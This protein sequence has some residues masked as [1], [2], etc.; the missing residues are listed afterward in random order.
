MRKIYI[1]FIIA[2]LG[3]G[4]M[5]TIEP[6]S[7]KSGEADNTKTSTSVDVYNYPFGNE[8][9][10]YKAVINLKLNQAQEANNITV[11]I[12]FLKYNKTLLV[13]LTQDDCK[14]AAFSTTWAA[15][16]G[17][18][19]S[20][21]YYYTAQQMRHGD[22]PPDT[23]GFGKSLGSTDGTGNEV[24]FSFATAILAENKNMGK[25]STIDIGHT[26]D[27]YRFYMR[28][29]LSWDDV[30]EMTNFGVS[31][32]MHDVETSFTELPDSIRAHYIISE[33]ITRDSLSGR[34]CKVLAEPNGNKN[35]VTAA[36]TYEPLQF[37]VLQSGGERITPLTSDKDY[38]DEPVIRDF[39]E[40]NDVYT[41]IEKQLALPVAERQAVN[42]G[43]HGTDRKWSEFLLWLNNFHGKD[44]DDCVW[45][46][47]PEEYFEYNYIR[48]HA[49]VTKTADGT[50]LQIT[51]EIPQGISYYYPSMTINVKGLAAKQ[52]TEVTANDAVT[53]LSWKESKTNDVI[54]NID[55][56]QALGDLAEHFVKCYEN[57]HSAANK[58]DAAYFVAKL[59][60]SS[61]K[62]ALLDRIK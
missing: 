31:I 59:K 10:S 14:Q 19:L 37:I 56:R 57:S 3:T 61:R 54:I 44:G 4:C 8:P 13:M 35:Y 25:S 24:R 60:D 11:E 47:S 45:M 26:S 42:L 20:D 12:P 49:T 55:C 18:P 32:A 2:L 62:T 58:A 28:P 30:R 6:K 41:E 27:Y 53:G 40:P 1:C 15:I 16:N 7:G 22:L 39:L 29:C 43:V 36:K 5:K 34:N 51:I 23:Y 48:R 21:K 33:K 46:T 38:L 52:C 9:S 50:N 17:H